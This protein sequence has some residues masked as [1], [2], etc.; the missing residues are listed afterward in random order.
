MRA[1]EKNLL[2][3]YSLLTVKKINLEF[4]RSLSDKPRVCDK[5]LSN[6]IDCL[7]FT[8]KMTRN[9]PVDR[10]KPETKASGKEY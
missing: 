1:C 5:T 9:S 7:A 6:A 2:E 8:L 3:N 4:K 10:Y